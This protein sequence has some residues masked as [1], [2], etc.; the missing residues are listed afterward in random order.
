LRSEQHRAA[1]PQARPPTPERTGLAARSLARSAPERTGLANRSLAR[2]APERTDLVA[3]SLARSV[4]EPEDL[5]ACCLA[6]ADIRATG[7]TSASPLRSG[8]AG[9][10]GG[11]SSRVSPALAISPMRMRKSVPISTV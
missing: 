5:G 6:R 11:G 7:F 1:S 8:R 2:S 3:C 10:H 4:P 9:A